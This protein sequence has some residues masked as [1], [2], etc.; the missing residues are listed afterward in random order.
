MRALA[1]GCAAALALFAAA[2]AHTED[3]C[4]YDADAMMRLDYVAFDETPESGWRTIGNTP[5]CE[6]AAADL[7]ARYRVD[8]TG[9]QLRGLM[10][11]EV[12]LRAAAGQTE[13]ALALLANVRA[14]ETAPEMQAYRDAEIAFLSG[15][16]PSLR[17]ARERLA[18]VPAPEGFEEGVARFRAR[19]PTLQPP[20]WPMNLDVVD[21]FIN[22][23]GRPYSEA[24]STAC[25]RAP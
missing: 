17:A 3:Q 7:I 6:A 23:F 14:M 24:Y 25:R 5:G 9:D 11:H 8:K 20:T 4:A 19:Y 13:A 18:N 10:H 2:C 21:G 1:F 16:L 12:Q 15:D 22:C